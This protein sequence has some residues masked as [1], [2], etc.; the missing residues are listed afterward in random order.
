MFLSLNEI[1]IS[2]TEAEI[3][4]VFIAVADG[5]MPESELAIWFAENT[6]PQE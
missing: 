2:A 5:A 1:E 3:A 4:D 6:V